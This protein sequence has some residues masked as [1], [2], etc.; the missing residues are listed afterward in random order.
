MQKLKS[1]HGHAKVG[2]ALRYASIRLRSRIETAALGQ[3]IEAE[4][5]ALEKAGEAHAQIRE[6]RVAAT[7]VI[8]HQD[9]I[10][11]AAVAALAREVMV[12]T[13][14][15]LDDPFYKSL[16][17]VAPSTATL[18]MA[19]DFQTRFVKAL[20]DRI[21]TDDRY[22]SLRAAAQTIKEAQAELDR[23]LTQRETL[24]APELRAEVDLKTALDSARRA[25]NKLY[26]KLSLLFESK[27]FIETFFVAVDKSGKAE[28]AAL[29]EALSEVEEEADV[30]E[31]GVG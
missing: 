7:A 10:V 29:D 30:V 8:W 3:E 19:S 9:S 11:D 2:R 16:F 23:L 21:E 31:S 14:G 25:Y 13:G 18:P 1:M 20:V 17:P 22:Q 26:P 5:A 28:Q 27:A 15:K 12:I 4:R 24:R 6:E